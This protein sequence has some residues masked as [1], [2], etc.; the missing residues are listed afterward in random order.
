MPNLSFNTAENQWRFG[1]CAKSRKMSHVADFLDSYVYLLNN[2]AE[3]GDCGPGAK[4]FEPE[5][6]DSVDEVIYK[7]PQIENDICEDCYTYDPDSVFPR[8]DLSSS[9]RLCDKCH[10]KSLRQ[11]RSDEQHKKDLNY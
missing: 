10:F 11:A 2:R 3:D 4:F 5:S 1:K 6:T 8:A 9:P 7:S